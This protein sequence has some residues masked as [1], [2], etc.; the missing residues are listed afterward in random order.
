MVI[1]TADERHMESFVIAS[2]EI[3]GCPPHRFATVVRRPPAARRD[4]KSQP[5]RVP[6]ER[7]IK[8]SSNRSLIGALRCEPFFMLRSSRK[9]VTLATEHGRA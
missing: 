4:G 9:N 5:S 7:S 3:G 8:T 2:V 6:E 1:P